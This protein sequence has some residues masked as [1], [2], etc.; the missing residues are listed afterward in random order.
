MIFKL[1]AFARALNAQAAEA[2]ASGSA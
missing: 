2:H 1:A